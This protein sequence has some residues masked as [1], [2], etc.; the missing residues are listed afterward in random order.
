MAKVIARTR[1]NS[2]TTISVGAHSTSAES[3]LTGMKIHQAT[4]ST[5]DASL[6][7]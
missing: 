7:R 5:D 6:M 1:G 3:Q 4:T 2:T